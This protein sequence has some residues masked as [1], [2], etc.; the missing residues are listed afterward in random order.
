MP[1]DDHAFDDSRL[2]QALHDAAP[3]VPTSGVVTQ[4]TRRRTQ[5][6]RNRRLTAGALAVVAVLVV[7]TGTVLVTARRQLV[8]AH[9]VAGRSVCRRG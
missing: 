4:V 2:E 3:T 6:R 7:G 8:T 5:R 9:R 1:T